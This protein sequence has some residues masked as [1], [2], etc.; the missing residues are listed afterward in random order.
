MND[1]KGAH[2]I[3]YMRDGRAPIPEKPLTSK[4]MRA[5]KAKD[6]KPEVLLRKALRELG[7]V[8]YRLHYKKVPGRPDIAFVGKKLAI[9]VNGC[10]WHRC[11]YCDLP[12]PKSNTDWW[13]EKFERNIKRDQI[14]VEELERSGW[15][16]LVVWECEIKTQLNDKVKLIENKLKC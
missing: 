10:F 3:H 13:N 14:K 1:K 15:K 7:L 9:F 4:V 6:T 2:E 11:P 5:N 8:G 16:V 12:L